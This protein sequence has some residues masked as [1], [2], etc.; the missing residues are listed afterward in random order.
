MLHFYVYILRCND[1]SYYVG[2]T[3]NIE[4]RISEHK[5]KLCSGYTASRLPVDL[6]FVQEFANRD[7]AIAAERAIK[8]WRRS[9]KEALIKGD[10]KTLIELSNKK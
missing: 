3:D 4:Q 2:H 5:L 10:I 6:V 9:K 1:A 7:E 8:G